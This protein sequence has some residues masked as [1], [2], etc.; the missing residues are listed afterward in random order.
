MILSINNYTFVMRIE[1]E[2]YAKSG[3]FSLR[4]KTLTLAATVPH[5]STLSYS[6][7]SHIVNCIFAS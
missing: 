4:V 5:S 7:L 6:P 2:E 1:G 3:P